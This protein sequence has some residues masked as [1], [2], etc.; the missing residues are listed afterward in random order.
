[1]TDVPTAALDN[2]SR[3]TRRF[4]PSA[5]FAAQ[6]NVDESIYAEA[7]A[8]RLAF[9]AKR[10]ER[11][12][13]D[14]PFE[15]VLDWSDAPFAKWFVGGKLNVAVNCLDRHVAAGLGDRVAYFFEG[16]PGDTRTITY[17]ELTEEVCQA[18]NVLTDLGV[19]AGD[20]VAIYMPMIPEAVVAML[21][22]AR[23]GAPHTVVFGG[24]S[25][26]ALATRILDCDARVVITADGG[27]RKGAITPL[28][29]A[30]DEALERCPDVRNVL[31]V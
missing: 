3:E 6:A 11:L 22:C 26:D 10:A 25:A 29:P 21:A 15:Q 16:E 8:D 12:T 19:K 20:R 4:P 30:V 5:E 17:R 18:A 13:W 24:F 28:K 23:L 9:W 31:V 2:L 1:M 7:D 14:T 27:W